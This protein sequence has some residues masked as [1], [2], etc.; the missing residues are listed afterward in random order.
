MRSRRVLLP[1][2]LP[3]GPGDGLVVGP[4]TQRARK[5]G[6]YGECRR[7]YVVPP[8]SGQMCRDMLDTYERWGPVWGWLAT[9]STPCCWRVAVPARWRE[10]TESQ[11]PGSMS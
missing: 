8:H 3:P 4:D 6:P 5:L 2:L 7:R 9:W 11:R 1:L 10:P